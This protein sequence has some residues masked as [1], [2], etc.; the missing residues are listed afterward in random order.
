MST[1]TKTPATPRSKNTNEFY[2]ELFPEPLYSLNFFNRE[3]AGAHLTGCLRNSAPSMLISS[4]AP[5]FAI[6]LGQ[7]RSTGH[8]STLTAPSITSNDVKVPVLCFLHVVC[9]LILYVSIKISRK[10]KPRETGKKCAQTRANT[11]HRPYVHTCKTR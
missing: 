7:P 2:F 4:G 5:Q 6:A 8:V 11:V 3:K 1:V 10:T 9:H